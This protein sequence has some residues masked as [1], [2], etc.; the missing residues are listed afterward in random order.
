MSKT[1][2]AVGDCSASVAG[3]SSINLS[4]KA[5]VPA[6][7]TFDD[8][9]YLGDVYQDGTFTEFS[10]DFD[11]VW[12]SYK[13]MMHSTPGNHGWANH[14]SGF[15]TY[16]A[17]TPT[18]V[19]PHYG[20]YMLGD[21]M[22]VW[23]NS[24]EGASTSSSPTPE[25]ALAF[26]G[27]N[28]APIN[29]A[30][31][32]MLDWLTAT[33]QGTPGTAKI[34]LCHHNVWASG[35]HG[36]I[37][38]MKPIWDI[39]VGHAALLITGHTHNLEVHQ[40]RD[41][42]G[43]AVAFNNGNGDGSGAT[44]HVLA[45]LAGNQDPLAASYTPTLTYGA[46]T[47][48]A[49][50]GVLKIVLSDTGLAN[51]TIDLTF[52]HTDG[53]QTAISQIVATG[54]GA[55]PPPPPPPPGYVR[56]LVRPEYTNPP[57]YVLDSTGQQIL[58]RGVNTIQSAATA[59]RQ[60]GILNLGCNFVRVAINW[61]KFE[62]A[63]PTGSGTDYTA[64]GH[65]LNAAALAQLDSDLAYYAANG[66]YF[67]LDFHQAAWS[68]YFGGAGVPSWYYTS[69]KF[70][71]GKYQQGAASTDKG[72][73]IGAWWTTELAMSQALYIA[74]VEAMITH[75]MGQ[76]YVD[77]LVGY[78][79]FNE[80]NAGNLGGSSL[81]KTN[82]MHTWLAPVVDAICAMDAERAKWIMCRGGGQGYGS[83][84]FAQFGD[85]ASKRVCLEFHQ[86]YTG[87]APG[88]PAVAT[89]DVGYDQP[90]DDY[91]PNSNACH[92]TTAGSTY[93]GAEQYQEAF[94]SVPLGKAKALGVPAFMGELG[95][96]PTDS[97][98][99]NYVSD[100][101][102]ALDK[103]KVSGT[104]WKMG[105]SPGD[106]LGILDSNGNLLDTG[107]AWQT[108][109]KATQYIVGGSTPTPPAVITKPTISDLNPYVGEVI[110]CDP[111]VWS[112]YPAP[113]FT[114]QWQKKDPV[115][116]W[117]SATGVGNATASY[118]VDAS[119]LGLPLRCRVTGTNASG[120]LNAFEAGTNNV[121]SA[122]TGVPVVTTPP[123]VTPATAVIAGSAVSCTTGSWTNAPTG[124]SYQWQRK[125]PVTGAV[126]TITGATS[127][128]YTPTT[129][130]EA[131]QLACTVTATNASGSGTALSN[132]TAA[133]GGP[134]TATINPDIMDPAPL[135]GERIVV[136]NGEWSPTPTSYSYRWQ[137]DGGT[138][139]VT[140]TDISGATTQTYLIQSGDL[141]AK[142]RCVVTATGP[143]G[144]TNHTTTSTSPVAATGGV[145]VPD[146][147]LLSE[148]TPFSGETVNV[149]NPACSP[150]AGT[151]TYQWERED[152]TGASSNIVGATSQSYTVA[153]GDIGYRLRCKV[154]VANGSGSHSTHTVWTDF[155][156]SGSAPTYAVT[157]DFPTDGAIVNSAQV[158]VQVEVDGSPSQVL[159]SADGGVG[160]Q[161][162]PVGANGT[163]T[164]WG[165]TVSLSGGP[166][167]HKISAQPIR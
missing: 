120:S 91:F 12:G 94:M 65:T 99:L 49:K 59:D 131:Y 82:T 152:N 73:A 80:P 164:L 58:L 155:V 31:K 24:C 54:S 121:V 85:L 128:T 18:F 109:F 89:P 124:Y 60:S 34:V 70:A 96:H 167:D 53:T 163:H 28:G 77:H 101:Q 147:P 123:A 39:I 158:P 10:Q 127:S 79:V 64:Y 7:G 27:V 139:G 165:G 40:P 117:G 143:G 74:F 68:P 125:D 166:G 36:D 47:S 106:S 71:G 162:Q 67:Q 107:Q 142:L 103:L 102:T 42:S 118:T 15:D 154:T 145:P 137:S 108:W 5:L 104:V 76:G 33:M 119:D 75:L 88:Y 129:A 29:T 17:G 45:A 160:V 26:G 20:S 98:R 81:S 66:I 135:V 63:T 146:V 50:S 22:I 93:A 21:V 83:A 56:P 4:C 141:G 138:G 115:S 134:E 1:V 149:S 25:T 144:S 19:S 8:F 46:D 78:Q 95:V 13:S 100:V 150:P 87:K 30:S 157:W 62:T 92:T 72:K 132:Y 55:P 84:T 9:W 122:P 156:Q 2:Y 14:V 151:I 161:A 140:W 110:T 114:Y 113:T 112:G 105:R 3:G 90:G 133:P 136:D 148:P 159:L 16:H 126:S 41:R 51:P 32:A 11:A 43:G 111:G 97:G 116:G 57:R 153:V 44:I 130:D 37:S 48:P 6:A 35:G 61:D 23:V 86:Y 38:Q 52:L 69:A